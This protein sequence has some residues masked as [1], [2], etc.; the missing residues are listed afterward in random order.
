MDGQTIL[1]T[2]AAG[3]IGTHLCQRLAAKAVTVH[4]VSRSLPPGRSGSVTRSRADLTDAAETRRLLRRCHPDIIIHLA[5][6]PAAAR[7]PRLVLPT[8]HSN[9]VTTVNLLVAAQELGQ[10]HLVL[11][12]SFEEPDPPLAT[13]NSPYA[14]SK[15]CARA[16]GQMFSERYGLPVTLARIFMTYGPTTNHLHK[17]IP[18][19]IL[20]LLNGQA[21]HLSSG[22]R[23][24]DW[25]HV[26]DVVSGLLALAV[27]PAAPN[28]MIRTLDLG[29]GALTPIR[30]VVTRIV[31]LM[32]PQPQ[33]A[34]L[35]DPVLDRPFE[36]ERVANLQATRDAIG[37]QPEIGLN[38]GLAAT[39]EWFQRHRL[40][41]AAHGGCADAHR[42]VPVLR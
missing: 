38:Q 25:I 10:P 16:Y 19:V 28:G 40:Q 23:G 24:L 13:A 22:R 31:E 35:F 11:A 32:S 2:G 41:T 26:D 9:L 29:S 27:A 18:Y 33:D 17:V 20:S 5:G 39:V 36:Q 6:L 12:G 30:E 37:W 8:F 15:G 14:L 42:Q 7:D 21:P 3:F 4:A 34:P 1:V